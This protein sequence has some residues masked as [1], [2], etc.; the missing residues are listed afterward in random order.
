MDA[1]L[2]WNIYSKN[3]CM[4]FPQL[5]LI[6]WSIIKSEHSQKLVRIFCELVYQNRALGQS[7]WKV[8]TDNRENKPFWKE[9]LKGLTTIFFQTYV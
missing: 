9:N 2:K 6:I 4:F 3:K 1:F 7:R 8:E 5:C